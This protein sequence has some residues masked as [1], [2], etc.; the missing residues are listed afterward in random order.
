MKKI[1]QIDGGGIMGTIPATVLAHLEKK[2]GTPLCECFDLITGISTGAI[3]GGAIAASVP[4]EKVA[5][6]YVDKSKKLITRR[7]LWNPKNW[8]RS[9][10]DRQPF[11]EE[12]A[13]IETDDNKI[14]LGQ[15]KLS[16]LKTRFMTTSFNLCSQRTHFIKSWEEHGKYPL[17]DVMSWSALS[18]AYY[19]GQINVSSYEWYHYQPDYYEQH[20]NEPETVNLVR[21]KG[22]IFQDEGQGTHNN[23]LIH[24]LVEILANR[25]AQDEEI[26]ILSLGAGNLDQYTSYYKATQL[27]KRKP[28]SHALIA[29]NDFI[30]DQVL[31]S[32]HVSRNNP[33]IHFKRIDIMVKKEEYGLDKIEYLEQYK[34]YGIELSIQMTND[35]LRVLQ[36]Q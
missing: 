8:G 2:L 36:T 7:P 3:I 23:A 31:A 4:A 6:L 14:S 32:I 29:R 20:H 19:F 28:F 12:I 22:A 34:Q 11:L 35:E 33:K 5:Q 17:I 25:W 18:A 24:I 13:K 30:V 9:K 26:Y 16:E 10:Y 21:K 27:N 1:L 15:L